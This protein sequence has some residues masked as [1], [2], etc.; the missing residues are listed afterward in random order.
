MT[1]SMIKSDPTFLS[2]LAGTQTVPDS[3]QK[4]N[5]AQL[6]PPN[7]LKHVSKKEKSPKS[8]PKRNGEIK[9]AML[10]LLLLHML[11]YTSGFNLGALVRKAKEKERSAHWKTFPRINELTQYGL[12]VSFST[13][14]SSTSKQETPLSCS[15]KVNSRE[16]ECKTVSIAQLES[17]LTVESQRLQQLRLQR[18]GVQTYGETTPP[19][20][21][22]ATQQR[23]IEV[24]K[25]QLVDLKKTLELKKVQQEAKKGRAATAS[26]NVG[27]SLKLSQAVPVDLIQPKSKPAPAQVQQASQQPKQ[28]S[29][30]HPLSS[31]ASQRDKLYQ[32][33]RTKIQQQSTQ[34]Q[35]PSS[36]SSHLRQQAPGQ[37]QPKITPVP[38]P[39]KQQQQLAEQRTAAQLTK[40]QVS[41]SSNLGAVSSS[42][43]G[44]QTRQPGATA[45]KEGAATKV[46]GRDH[47]EG[48]GGTW[49]EKALALRKKNEEVRVTQ[50]SLKIDSTCNLNPGLLPCPVFIMCSSGMRLAVGLIYT[51]LCYNLIAAVLCPHYWSQV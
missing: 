33:V 10:T 51:K 2:W 42:P 3:W 32:T 21:S 40:A 20:E 27:K 44:D 22:T 23:R 49:K 16:A 37:S 1:L 5:L 26:S 19:T 14:A 45:G 28:K 41:R 39:P 9:I 47:V 8:P 17:A 38:F 7:L 36:P 43:K 4:W 25:E 29:A 6:E 46:S 15:S 13:L 18:G 12:G 35:K 31:S 34:L 48:S 11:I 50:M 24:A 30:A